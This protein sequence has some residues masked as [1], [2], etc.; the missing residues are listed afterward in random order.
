MESTTNAETPSVDLD[1][2][3]SE[4]DSAAETFP[5]EAIRAAQQNRELVI[6]RL[7]ESIEV[8]TAQATARNNVPDGNAHFFA[9]FL[10]TEFRA[11]EALPAILAAVSLPGELPEHL[12]GDAITEVLSRTLAVLARDSQELID[13]LVADRGHDEFVRCQ[14]LE[15]Y[16]YLVKD[17]VLTRDEAVTRLRS[18]L[19]N[20]IENGDGILATGVVAELVSF[21]PH[22]AIEEIRAAFRKGLVDTTIVG[23]KSVKKSIAEGEAWFQKELDCHR[24]VGVEDT[25]EELR[26]WYAYQERSN[27]TSSYVSGILDD[28]I[29]DDWDDDSSVDEPW[30]HPST[31]RNTEPRVGRNDPCPCG[32]GKKYKKCCGKN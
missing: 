15:S 25:V 12:F 6:P 22:E 2:I 32:S 28:E 7:I 14:G 9:L 21:A 20:A 4:L 13:S 3:I 18:H 30:D 19:V 11:K 23:L 5:E 1:W 24:P 16:F 29:D 17:G 10:L 8:A 27:S 26:G 31:I